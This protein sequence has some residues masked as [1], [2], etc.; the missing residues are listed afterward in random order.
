MCSRQCKAISPWGAKPLHLPNLKYTVPGAEIDL[1]GSYGIDG[2][3][4][5][6]AGFARTDAKVSQL[7]GGWKGLLLKPAD[8]LFKKDGAGTQ[9]PI[10]IDGTRENPKFG[11]DL[12]RMK[13][14]A[15]QIPGQSQ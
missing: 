4:L 14:T 15:P 5:N 10:H 7:V 12:K 8:R 1:K 2:G 9:V 6:F 3:N 11:I 13:H